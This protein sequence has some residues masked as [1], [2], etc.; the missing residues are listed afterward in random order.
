MTWTPGDTNGS[1][2]AQVRRE[3]GDPDHGLDPGRGGRSTRRPVLSKLF[4]RKRKKR[5]D[6]AVA[7]VREAAIQARDAARVAGKRARDAAGPVMHSARERVGP[8]MESA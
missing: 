7:D 3:S 4:G 5:T 1:P 8:A 6:E 2:H